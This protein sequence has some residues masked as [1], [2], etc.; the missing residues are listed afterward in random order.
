MVKI[1][2]NISMSAQQIF[3]QFQFLRVYIS[4]DSGTC[5]VGLYIGFVDTLVSEKDACFWVLCFLLWMLK[6]G[7]GTSRV[8]SSSDRR[9]HVWRFAGGLVSEKGACF[10]VLCVLLWM[11]TFGR[12]TSHAGSS[13]DRRRHFWRFF[14]DLESRE[15]RVWEYAWIKCIG[16]FFYRRRRSK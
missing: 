16:L 2:Q 12:G 15:W 11:L 10:W 5:I 3:Y 13:S 8:G 9:R 4:E 6:C 1:K 7:R 14:G